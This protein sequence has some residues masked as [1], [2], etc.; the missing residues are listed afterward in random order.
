MV[1]ETKVRGYALC[2]I[3]DPVE[4]NLIFVGTENGLWVSF[5]NGSTFQ[6]WKNGYPSGFYLR[7]GYTRK[8]G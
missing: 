2:M 3:Q 1:D 8:R 5:D 4:A 6:Q 7:Y